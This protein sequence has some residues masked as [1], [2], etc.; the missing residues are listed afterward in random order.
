MYML[1]G[2]TCLTLSCL[3]RET[4][5]CW[6]HAEIYVRWL[7]VF[8]AE[9]SPKRDTIVLGACRDICWLVTRV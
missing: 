9:L 7:H 8:N 5:S 1:V 4:R 3:R 6:E 2:Y